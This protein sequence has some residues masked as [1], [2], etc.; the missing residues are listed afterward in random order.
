M[1]RAIAGLAAAGLTVALAGCAGAGRDEDTL[2]ASAAGELQ[3]FEYRKVVMAIEARLV[4][5]APDEATAKAAASAAFDVLDGMDV[6][7]SDYRADG[8]VAKMN[9][10]A[11]ARPITVSLAVEPLIHVFGLADRM[12]VESG[13]AFDIAAGPVITCWREARH[14]ARL[15]T[16]AALD[17]ARRAGGGWMYVESLAGG[18]GPGLEAPQGTRFDLG[19]IAKGYALG[20]A[21]EVARNQGAPAVLLE[22]GGDVVVTGAPPGQAGWRIALGA[23]EGAPEL[24]LD[25]GAVSVSGAANQFVEIDG[26]RYSHVVDPRTGWAL[27]HG[28]AAAVAVEPGCGIDGLAQGGALADA[29][30]TAA[31]VLGPHAGR[32]LAERLGASLIRITDP[33]FRPLFD[34]S[35]LTNWTP[36]GGRYDGDALWSVEDGCLTGRTGPG[37]AG[38][39][40]YTQAPFTSFELQLECRLEPPFDSG[41]FVRM[42][43]DARGAQLTLDDRPD[44][45]IGALFSDGFLDHARP[46]AARA[47]RRGDWNHVF[48]RCTGFDMRVEVWINGVPVLDHVVPQE[49]GPDGRP[50]FAP[51]GLIGLQVHGGGSE[52]AGHKVQFRDIVVRELP[53]LGEAFARDRALAPP[54]REARLA[55]RAADGW[56]E[57]FAA[58]PGADGLAAWEA[59]DGE[60][61]PR[62]PGDYA[63]RDGVLHIPSSDPPG[64]LRTR[65]D[66]RDFDLTLQFRQARMSNSGLFLR[67]RRESTGPDGARVPGGNPAFSGCEIQILDDWNWEAGTNSTLK[68]WQFTGSLYGALPPAQEGLL[69]PIGGWNTLE[70]TA[71]GP[72]LAC[73]LNGQALWDVDTHALAVDPPFAQRAAEGFL[74]L[75]RY[76][77]PGVTD[78]AALEVREMWVRRR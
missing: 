33:A 31:T 63:V 26:V 38:G 37:D 64:Y 66:F 47:W 41:V 50:V 59:V 46:E 74:G 10:A 3:R 40:L 75:Q 6:Y 14:S 2:A 1:K 32:L 69:A 43:P 76:A 42:A 21:V 9:A 65:E 48:L 11:V 5:Y 44:G 49:F 60:D 13:G 17:A 22:L 34:G 7:F 58:E 27:T 16:V 30:A 25:Q 39:L 68:D 36:R 18:D 73:A 35:T 53:V 71:R 54:E 45:E 19:G 62:A 51:R 56:R 52:A 77:A 29:L 4:L 70:L 61:D 28:L 15:P 8:V 78:A 24:I 23:A 72:R 67:G 12:R 57:L 55:D 20:R